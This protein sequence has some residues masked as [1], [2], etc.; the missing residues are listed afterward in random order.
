MKS[1]FSEVKLQFLRIKRIWQYIYIY[2]YILTNYKHIILT[3][4]PCVCIYCVIAIIT[5]NI[6][7]IIMLN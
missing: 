7:K 2:I 6:A 1:L 5:I 3:Y 4:V